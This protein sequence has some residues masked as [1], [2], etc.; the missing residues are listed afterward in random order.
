MPS[1]S[2]AWTLKL[3]ETKCV[4]EQSIAV[5]VALVPKDRLMAQQEF[6]ETFDRT[7]RVSPRTRAELKAKIEELQGRL[8][9]LGPEGNLVDVSDLS[10][11]ISKPMGVPKVPRK[12]KV[13]L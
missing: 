12:Y 10:D 7:G 3:L 1:S 5:V 8:D 9:E 2:I 6:C 4:S 11:W 13:E